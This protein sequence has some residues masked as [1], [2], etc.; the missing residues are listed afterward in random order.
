MIGIFF[1]Y[2]TSQSFVRNEVFS[3]LIDFHSFISGVILCLL[4]ESIILLL[5]HLS[6][7]MM[8]IWLSCVYQSIFDILSI[9][10]IC[11]LWTYQCQLALNPIAP[12]QLTEAQRVLD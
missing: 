2:T 10:Y 4:N 11:P 3:F 12:S 7:D 1:R 6:F 9:Y 5:K 8:S